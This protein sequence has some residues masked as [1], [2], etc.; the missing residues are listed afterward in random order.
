MMFLQNQTEIAWNIV[1]MKNVL[2]NSLIRQRSSLYAYSN[3]DTYRISYDQKEKKEIHSWKNPTKHQTRL[4]T[5]EKNEKYD[6]KMQIEYWA[7]TR[8]RAHSLHWFLPMCCQLWFGAWLFS[9]SLSP[10]LYLLHLAP[11]FSS[12]PWFSFSHLL[13]VSFQFYIVC[14]CVYDGKLHHIQFERIQIG[15]H[16]ISIH[17]F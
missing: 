14:V 12:N 3:I 15:R 5:K 1:L 16:F 17:G 10:S 4:T 9:L 8:A 11:A 6:N 7:G 13:S 2:R